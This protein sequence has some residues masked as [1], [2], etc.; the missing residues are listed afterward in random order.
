LSWHIWKYILT[1][2]TRLFYDAVTNTKV[3][4]VTLCRIGYRLT[5]CVVHESGE[6]LGEVAA[7]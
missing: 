1:L 5:G 7:V 2:C 3:F 4:K 6:I